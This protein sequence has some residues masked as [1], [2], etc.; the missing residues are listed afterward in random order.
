MNKPKLQGILFFIITAF[1]ASHFAKASPFIDKPRIGLALQGGGAKGFA[2]IGVLQWLE[3]NRIPAHLIAGTSMGGL[4]GGFYAAGQSP[5]ELKDLVD[6]LNWDELIGGQPPFES[7]SFRRKEDR[8]AYPNRLEFGLR[9]GFSLPSGL[10]SGH[11]IGLVLDRLTLPYYALE[12]FDDLPI[13]FRCVAI[14]L[15]SGTETVFSDG[16]LRDA[17]R[18]TMSLPAIFYPLHA[19]GKIYADGG[20]LNNLPVDAAKMMGADIVIA[21]NLD[22]GEYNSKNLKSLV[23]VLGRSLDVMMDSNVARSLQMA[24][25]VVRV[26]VKG[27]STLDFQLNKAIIRKGYEAAQAM[28]AE[29]SRY[30]LPENEWKQYLIDRVSRKKTDIPIPQFLEVEG[31]SSD[32]ASSIRKDLRRLPGQPLDSAKL[33][34]EIADIWGRG[35]FAAIG[36]RLV[37]RNTQTG[38]LIRPEEKEYSPPTLNLNIDIDGSDVGNVRFGLQARLTMPDFG[39]DRSEWRTDIGFGSRNLVST[40]YYWALA[41]SPHWFLAPRAYAGNGLLD[42]YYSGDRISEY[43]VSRG[44]FGVDGGYRFNRTTEVRIGHDISWNK[45]H[46]S[47]GFALVDDYSHFVGASTMTIRH[48]GRDDALVPRR[49]FKLE[50]KAEWLSSRPYGGSGFPRAEAIVQWLHPVSGAGSIFFAGAGG[51]AFD[52]DSLGLLSF[53]L[54]GILRLGSYGRN[55]LLGNQYYLITAGYLHEIASLPRLIGGGI[56]ATGWYQLGKM[57]GNQD[58]PEHPMDVS[59][60]II[61]KT[62]LGPIFV[63]GSWGDGDHRKLYFGLGKIF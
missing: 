63:G 22:T 61:A 57:Y 24:D 3:E 8:L 27:F 40:E 44:G 31:V 35:R 10:N 58:L 25:L 53:S 36:Y 26:D 37:D 43:R 11:E 60:G 50:A 6:T 23:G 1:I 19:D 39:G 59:G 18:A 46:L 41:R 29:L 51:S 15:V 16:S 17:L 49:G 30:A 7:L 4:I 34:R 9:N 52:R 42:I 14:D 62:L 45:A 47:T 5:A 12:S 13:P 28:G 32:K 54:G 21:V 55:E 48:L 56:Y 33:E 20:M 2:H 38:L